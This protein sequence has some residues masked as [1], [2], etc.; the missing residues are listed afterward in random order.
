[1]GYGQEKISLC[2]SVEFDNNGGAVP[3]G[4][5]KIQDSQIGTVTNADGTFC[6]VFSEKYSHSNLVFSYIGYSDEV[7]SISDLLALEGVK[8][9]L[10]ESVTIM[11]EAVVV[12]KKQ[13]NPLKILKE[14][15]GM[16]ENNYH[17]ESI[18]FEGLQMQH[19]SSTMMPTRRVDI[20]RVNSSN[21]K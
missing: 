5:V 18:N 11:E 10:N 4:Y 16:I 6:I 3:F 20:K 19:V 12:N 14:S 21:Y 13:L 15:L 9:V 2:G 17:H 8:I 7:R 1:M